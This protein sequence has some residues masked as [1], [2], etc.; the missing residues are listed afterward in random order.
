MSIGSRSTG[1]GAAAAGEV[2]PYA[3]PR[4]PQFRVPTF[5]PNL[6]PAA[7]RP[8]PRIDWVQLAPAADGLGLVNASN[9]ISL[10]ALIAGVALSSGGIWLL[11]S[12]CDPTTAGDVAKGLSLLPDGML[13]AS[14][15]A[16]L[17]AVAGFHRCLACP[18]PKGSKQ[19]LWISLLTLTGSAA[20]ALACG[21]G[22]LPWWLGIVS[23]FLELC[24]TVAFLFYLQNLAWF[25]DR[26]DL[27]NQSNY[28]WLSMLA[29]FAAIVAVVAVGAAT[30]SDSE[31][32]KPLAD[33]FI[34]GSQPL[35]V[36]GILLV[37]LSAALV[38]VSWI[39]ITLIR[40]A[41]KEILSNWRRAAISTDD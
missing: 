7:S 16:T 30:L 3:A 36:V 32:R 29:L 11:T 24:A 38:L 35:D 9:W 21:V 12:G 39:Y 8:K 22:L 19:L 1:P 4:R 27:A 15:V 33:L 18:E 2:N 28:I 40:E 25:I 6:K 5:V 10:V 34:S 17:L 26:V 41:R 20:L 13:S 23:S 37:A 31:R 14:V